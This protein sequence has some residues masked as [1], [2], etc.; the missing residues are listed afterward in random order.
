MQ[1]LLLQY[2]VAYNHPLSENA[3]AVTRYLYYNRLEYEI[4]MDF[5]N[6]LKIFLNVQQALHLKQ[7]VFMT[8]VK[9]TIVF[10]RNQPHGF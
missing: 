7:L 5:T 2:Q 6:Y 4:K 3:V 9:K 1:L 8:D 10:F